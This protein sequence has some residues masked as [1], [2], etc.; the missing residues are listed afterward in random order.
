MN[1][2]CLFS[3]VQS[4][5]LVVSD[6]WRL[7]GL[8]HT[9]LP[10]PSL[11]PWACSNSC[12]LNRR[13]HPTISSSVF[14]FSSCPQSFPAPGSFP[15]SQLL[16][17]SGQSIRASAT[18]LSMNIQGW[19]P[20]GLTELILLCKGRS[21]IFSSTISQNH[22]FWG[23]QPSSLSNSHICTGLLRGEVKWK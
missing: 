15:K 9:R 3:L 1:M 22:Q 17:S 6:S 12:P 8:Q 10:C 23:T 4:S 16:A 21:R 13:C 2:A 7:R 20:F 19:F 11:S 14:S 18:V 5:C